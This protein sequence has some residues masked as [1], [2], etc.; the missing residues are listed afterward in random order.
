MRLCI[1]DL[2][3]LQVTIDQTPAG[4]DYPAGIPIVELSHPP[5]EESG[6]TVIV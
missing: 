4:E 2:L 5:F 3:S 6:I 1:V